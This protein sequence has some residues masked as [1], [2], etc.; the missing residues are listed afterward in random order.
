RQSNFEALFGSLPLELQQE[1][2]G[3]L[4]V[5]DILNLRLIS[6]PWH[7]LVASKELEIAFSYLRQP[8]IP[9]LA[10]QL[11]PPTSPTTDLLYIS[12][13]WRRYSTACGLAT[14]ISDWLTTDMFLQKTPDQRAE[15]GESESLIRRRL[16][17]LV[18]AM[19]HF[20]ETYSALRLDPLT[21]DVDHTILERQ[22]MSD[23]DDETLLQ[24]HQLFRILMAFQTRNLR[25]PSYMS[26]TERS[27]RGYR[28]SDPPPENV[29]IAMLYIGGLQQLF[30]LAKI[31]PYEKRRQ[32][33]DVWFEGVTRDVPCE[34][35]GS[36]KPTEEPASG[37]KD[38]GKAVLFPTSLGSRPAGGSPSVQGTQEI[39]RKLPVSKSQ[40]WVSTAESLLI[41][42]GKIEKVQDIK[43]DAGVLQ[44]LILR[45]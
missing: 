32:A 5:P 29:Q 15:F 42:R 22:I 4:E 26:R 43:G 37:L 23:Y 41:E 40:I 17:P 18:I 20:F 31:Q 25:P 16:V 9:A 30:R 12:A 44:E 21:A 13:L 39:L 2:F 10:I 19:M 36:T 38:K 27:L 24:V 11:F 34:G 35:E 7:N 33:V 28:R 45:D 6:K 8:H 1:I 14:L 3:Y